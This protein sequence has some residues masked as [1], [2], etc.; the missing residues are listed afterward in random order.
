[1]FIHPEFQ[2][3]KFLRSRQMLQG[4][5]LRP[6]FYKS[7]ILLFLYLGQNFIRHGIIHGPAD[8]AHMFQ[9]IPSIQAGICDSGLC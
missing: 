5:P 1:M 8:T 2:A 7:Y 9:K 4:D 6:F 3:H